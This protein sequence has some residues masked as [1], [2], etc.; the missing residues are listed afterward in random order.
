[1]RS[2]TTQLVDMAKIGREFEPSKGAIALHVDDA[3]GTHRPGP[4]RRP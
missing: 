1:M 3:T 4:S 2:L